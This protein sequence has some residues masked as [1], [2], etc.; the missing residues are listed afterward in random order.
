M[1]N[2]GQVVE[3]SWV[4]V[5]TGEVLEGGQVTPAAPAPTVA[6]TPAG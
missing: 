6:P 3:R 1:G 5:D 4:V 2:V